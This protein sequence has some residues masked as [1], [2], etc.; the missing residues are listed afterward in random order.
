MSRRWAGRDVVGIETEVIYPGEF[1]LGPIARRP[2]ALA[3]GAKNR[4]LR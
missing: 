3:I 1:A 2:R 4:R